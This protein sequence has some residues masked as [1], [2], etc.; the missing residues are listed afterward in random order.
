MNTNYTYDK[1]KRPET[2]SAREVYT[3]VKSIKD[4]EQ[5]IV[6]LLCLDS[7]N[8]VISKNIVFI[9]TLNHSVVHPR[10]VLRIAILNNANSVILAHNHPSGDVNPSV[11]DRDITK[12]LKKACE[13]IGI[14]LLDHVIVGQGFYSFQDKGEL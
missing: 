10:D 14:P 7:R 2:S 12:K 1:G 13:L 3:L 4:K 9:G 6:I 5:E 11:D 8:K